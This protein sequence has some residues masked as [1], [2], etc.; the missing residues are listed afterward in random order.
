MRTL[1]II[2]AVLA[3]LACAGIKMSS[4]P[5]LNSNRESRQQQMAQTEKSIRSQFEDQTLELAGIKK[6]LGA[7]KNQNNPER[8]QK[9]SLEKKLA[10]LQVT[11]DGLSSRVEQEKSKKKPLV[12]ESAGGGDG[13]GADVD[14]SALKEREGVLREE[15]KAMQKELETLTPRAVSADAAGAGFNP[16][17][18]VQRCRI[19]FPSW[20]HPW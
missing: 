13:G 6:Q 9:T 15:I 20:C 3:V 5:T 4:A 10:D 7:L 17:P 1:G 16:V 14:D 12:A 18:P 2:L 8:A 19:R 11:I